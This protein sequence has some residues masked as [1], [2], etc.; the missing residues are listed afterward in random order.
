MY[1][2]PEPTAGVSPILGVITAA[3]QNVRVEVY[4]L[5]DRPILKAIKAAEARGVKVEV[6]VEGK[7]YR[8]SASQ[9]D[10]EENAIR[11]TGATLKLAPP[12]FTS[13]DGHYVFDHAKMI[14]N[15]HSC[16]IGTANFDWSAFHRNREYIS[17]TQNSTLVKAANAVFEADWN[18]RK[19][20][21]WTHQ[22]LVLSPGTSAAQLEKVI[23]Q[24]GP[25]MIE[26][27]ELGP[28]KPI[29][30]AIAVKGKK[31]FLILPS[32]IEKT[33]L[34][35][36]HYLQ[37]HGVQIRLMPKNRLYMHAKMITG[38]SY[39]FIGSE[40]FTKTSLEFNREVGLIFEGDIPSELAGIF[41]KDWAKAKP[42][43]G[44]S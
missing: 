18:R 35:S 11:A 19:A 15:N 8:M 33:E 6:M 41:E 13:H 30:N 27:E 29:L 17:V 37:A 5:S 22:V 7:P 36:V 23:D 9:V 32:S 31:A 16:E 44:L 20:P 2:L 28:Y 34:K 42:V 3:H 43:H 39:A 38:Q 21:A 26:S 10:K 40:N 1:V 14:C 24:P 4:Y 12:R 25:V